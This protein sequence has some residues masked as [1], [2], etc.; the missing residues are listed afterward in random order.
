MNR[1]LTF[2]ASLLILTF[3]SCKEPDSDYEGVTTQEI[4]VDVSDPK[5]FKMSQFFDTCFIVPL[6]IKRDDN[7]VLFIYRFKEEVDLD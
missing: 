1:F 5:T 2:T 4:Y 7:P 6:D 3:F